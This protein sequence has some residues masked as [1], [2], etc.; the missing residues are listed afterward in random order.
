MTHLKALPKLTLWRSDFRKQKLVQRVVNDQYLKLFRT[1]L[2]S[3]KIL[4]IVDFFIALLDNSITI[5]WWL[6]FMFSPLFNE[7]KLTLIKHPVLISSDHLL[8]SCMSV[9]CEKKLYECQMSSNFADDYSDAFNL[10][11]L[12]KTFDYVCAVWK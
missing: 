9:F 12:I 2:F 3:H 10:N 7:L 11:Q 5:C 1:H 4:R 6:Y 8:E